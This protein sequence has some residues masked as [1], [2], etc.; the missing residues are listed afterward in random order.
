MVLH[1]ICDVDG[2]EVAAFR[3]RKALRGH[4][5]LLVHR[6]RLARRVRQDQEGL[7]VPP[8]AARLGPYRSAS[9]ATIR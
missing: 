6:V 3:D 9:A 7:P 5:G 2:H 4:K 8:M 1:R